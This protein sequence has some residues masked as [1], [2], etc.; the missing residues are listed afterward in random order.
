MPILEGIL[1]AAAIG[2]AA[3]AGISAVKDGGELCKSSK[4][5]DSFHLYTFQQRAWHSNCLSV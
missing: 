2:G 1:A 3:A 5:R 4:V